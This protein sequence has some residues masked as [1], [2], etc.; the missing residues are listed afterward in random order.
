M[1]PPTYETSQNQL[2][3]RLYYLAANGTTRTTIGSP[4]V[5]NGL[6]GFENYAIES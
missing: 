4:L 1:V 5:I 3:A 2:T 6:G